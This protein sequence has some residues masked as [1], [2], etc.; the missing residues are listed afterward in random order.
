MHWA[1]TLPL[2]NSIE[3]DAVLLLRKMSLFLIEWSCNDRFITHSLWCNWIWLIHYYIGIIFSPKSTC[4]KRSK[5]SRSCTREHSHTFH[6]HLRAFAGWKTRCTHS[7]VLGDICAV[8]SF[9]A[10]VVAVVVDFTRHI[11]FFPLWKLIYLHRDARAHTHTHTRWPCPIRCRY[12]KVFD[13]FARSHYY[14]YYLGC[15]CCYCYCI[16]LSLPLCTIPPL[17]FCWFVCL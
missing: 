6:V 2:S 16:L 13:A 5:S 10:F 9:S 7:Y 14:Y 12:Q 4:V 3:N 1:V 11:W 8:L 15:C 17:L